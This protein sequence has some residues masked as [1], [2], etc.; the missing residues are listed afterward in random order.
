MHQKTNAQQ[1]YDNTLVNTLNIHTDRWPN[2]LPA[3]TWTV[4]HKGD[5]TLPL[6]TGPVAEVGISTKALHCD[7]SMSNWRRKDADGFCFFTRHFWKLHW[8]VELRIVGLC[9][10]FILIFIKDPFYAFFISNQVVF[11]CTSPLNCQFYINL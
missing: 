7:H 8:N 9:F 3:Q 11:I 1:R 10:L 2:T 4:I 5:M 6:F